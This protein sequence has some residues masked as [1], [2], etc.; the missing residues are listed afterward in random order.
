MRR[1]VVITVEVVTMTM[2]NSLVLIGTL[3][4]F[5][6]P[7]SGGKLTSGETVQYKCTSAF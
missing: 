6:A 5:G 3:I 2:Q 7:H 4:M 1:Y